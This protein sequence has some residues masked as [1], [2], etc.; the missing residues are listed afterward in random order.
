MAKV[1]IVGAGSVIF[2]MRLVRDFCVTPGLAGTTLALMDISEERLQR[3]YDLASRYVAETGARL[4][5]EKTTHRR[6]ALEGSDFV[7]NTVKVGGYAGMEAERAI[8]ERHGYY[9]GIDDPVSDYYGGFAAYHQLAFFLE[10]AREM[11]AVCPD[12]WYL[13]VAN[14]VFE[15]STLV[16]RESKLKVVG[17]CHGFNEYEE[18]VRA[19]ELD[20][21]GVEVQV[22]GFNHAIFLT[23]FRYR[24]EDA[25]PLLDEWIRS[26]AEAY[27]ESPAYLYEPWATQMSPAAVEMY[28]LYGLFPIGD[29]VRSVSP[30]W[31]HRDLQ[32]KRRW[33]P[34]GGPDSE[35]GWTFH[36]N[37]L[38]RGLETI[39]AAAANPEVS[40]TREFPPAPSGEAI[41]PFIDA[42]VNDKPARLVINIPNQG[43]IAG[44]PDDVFVEVAATVR[45]LRIEREP[46]DRLPRRLLLHV[47]LPRWLRMERVV[48]AFR[49]GDRTSLF[50]ALMDDPR[51]STPQQAEGLIEE[52]LAAPWNARLKEHYRAG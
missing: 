40:L 15:G 21:A 51:S 25:Y 47:L 52:I 1:A 45:G 16:G 43:A 35:V 4:R 7:I 3:I 23:R 11:E 8:A 9:R 20:P 46:V 6:E 32:A 49:E 2:S 38:Q 14:P 34:A 27:W 12:A 41:V 10:V 42:V 44:I 30:W 50:L 39:R 22:A 33:F 26:K 24:G 31:W 19:L 48:Q 5:L 37:R 36:L 17:F 13:Q 28:R 29:T 18:I